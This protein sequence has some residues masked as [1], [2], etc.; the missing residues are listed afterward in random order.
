MLGKSEYSFR[1]H[2]KD[3]EAA[4]LLLRVQREVSPKYE[5]AGLIKKATKLGKAIYF[6]NVKGKEHPV[7]ANVSGSRE[8]LA[9]ALSL[10]PKK[11]LRE[12]SER[13]CSSPRI[14]TRL[15][16]NAPVQQVIEEGEEA[17]QK[18]P[19]LTH[20]ERDAGDYI[21][22]GTVIAKDPDTGFR[23]ASFNRMM[24]RKDKRLGIRMMPPQH[25]GVIQGKVEAKNK[26]LEVA[27]V[28][29]NHPAEMVAS[30]SLL[31]FGKDHLD[32]AS[33]IRGAP[34]KTVRCKT[35][36]L[37]VPA[38]AELVIEGEIEANLREE[39]G[40]FGEFMDYY[41]EKGRNHVLKVRAVT[42][43]KDYIYQGLLCGTKEDLGI[44]ALSRELV[45]F[46]A[47]LNSGY[48]IQDV[49]LMPFI[50]NGVISL[51]KRSDGEPKNVM[52]AAFGAYSWL[53]YCVVVDEDV[54]IH[55]LEDVWWAIATR[56]RADKGTF[57]I[58]DALGFPRKDKW[59]IHRGKLGLDA[60]VPLELKKEFER[61]KIPG[62]NEVDF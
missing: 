35:V 34:V 23:N 36:D 29:G 45:V 42:H 1:D 38:D 18:I 4:G 3:L 39:E 49:S 31:P 21:T 60:T 44:L 5:I 52:M 46:N 27:I 9:L 16:T 58:P 11:F 61:K 24:V 55:D 20:F 19:F 50:F 43:R 30:A 7:A 10:D 28:L 47:L 2:L 15:V 51:R 37:E 57:S 40:P 33:S 6:E 59:Q 48:D 14:G 56:S 54:N 41:V 53:K 12:F 8:M 32:H 62:E 22:A 26:N 13:V 25:L 17:L